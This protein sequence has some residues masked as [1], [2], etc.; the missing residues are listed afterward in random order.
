MGWAWYEL[1][2]TVS[3]GNVAAFIGAVVARSVSVIMAAAFSVEHK[4]MG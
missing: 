3:A 1:T 4:N 2:R